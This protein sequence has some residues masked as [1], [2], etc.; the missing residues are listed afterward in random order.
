[1]NRKGFIG[2]SDCVKIMQGDWYDLWQVKTGRIDPEDLSDNIAV[3]LGVFT[4]DFN[5]KWFEKQHK[6]V[7][8]AHQ[9]EYI[10]KISGVMA[11][12]TID[13]GIRGY[14]TIVEAKHTNAFTNIDEQIARYMP[15]I[16]LYCRLANCEGAYL[17]VIFGN[18]KWESAHVA[19]D[20]DYFNSMWRWCQISGVTLFAMK[21]RLVLMSPPSTQTPL[22]LTTWSHVMHRSTTS[23]LTRQSLTLMVSNKTEHSKTQRKT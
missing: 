18:G 6:V 13:A 21:S 4:E 8:A 22:R 15:Q 1:M 9:K 3:Q 23:S 11:K 20:E 14:N 16:Q 19:Y 7:L 12:G 2:G 10:E 17:S 5:L